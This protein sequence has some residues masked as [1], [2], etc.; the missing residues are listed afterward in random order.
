MSK[1][2]EL[3][4]ELCPDGVEYKELGKVVEIRSGWGFPN[5]EQGLKHGE[6]PFYKVGDMNHEKNQQIMTVA[7]NYISL[8]TVKRLKCN[9]APKGTIIFPKIGAAIRTNKKRIL[10][11]TACYDNNVVGLIVGN[12]VLSRFLFF[13]M[14]SISLID[15]ADYSGAMPSIRKSTLEKYKIPVPPLPVQ[16]EIVRILDNFTELTTELTEELKAEIEARKKQY[17]YYRDWLLSQEELNKLCPDGVSYKPLWEV[18]I[19]DKKFNAVDKYKQHKTIN[20]PY[21][22]ASEL[23]SLEKEDGDVFL[24]STGEQTG[25]TTEELAGDNLC[26]GEVV[27]IPWG[28]TPNVKYYN[29]KFV[30][31]DNR[32]ATSIDTA[33][34]CNKF[35]YYWMQNNIDTIASFYRGSGIKHPNMKKV[36]D[37][38]IPIPPLPVQQEIVRILDNFTELTAELTTELT[39]ELEARQKQYEYYRDKLLSFKEATA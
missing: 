17:E 29:G 12:D 26:E 27:A 34:L 9:P 33:L 5:K 23:F 3:I 25:W 38:E 22:L 32:I 7:N 2:D 10:G 18:T 28:G 1:L 16:C 37:M 20:Y 15:F 31:A 11:Q 8:D 36:L 19:W 13:I 39:T 35:L 6:I 4:A 21:L 14:D 24:L 30:T